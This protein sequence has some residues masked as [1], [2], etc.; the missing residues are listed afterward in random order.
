MKKLLFSAAVLAIAC[1]SCKK[2]EDKAVETSSTDSVKVETPATETAS[3]NAAPPSKEEMEKAWGEYMTPGD[4]HKMLASETGNWTAAMTM[5]MDPAN[6]TKSESSVEIKMGLGGRYQESRYKGKV[7]GMDFEGIATVGYN[8]ASQKFE[9]TWR[10]NMGTGLMFTTGEYDPATKSI[11]FTGSSTDPMTKKDKK[12][13]ELY[14]IV[15][16]NTRKMEMF[17]DDPRGKEYKSMEIIL[18]RK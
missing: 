11:T 3:E 9:S 13:R 1:T 10:D 17:E 18:K 12:F 4:M 2:A 8:N 7:D 5:F 16:D 15:D 6:P 14:T